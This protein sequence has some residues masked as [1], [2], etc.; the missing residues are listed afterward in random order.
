VL[1]LDVEEYED[2]IWATK[3]KIMEIGGTKGSYSRI[4]DKLT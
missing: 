4:N 1:S 2:V 3:E